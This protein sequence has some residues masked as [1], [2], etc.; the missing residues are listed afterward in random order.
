[1]S[2][3]TE[4]EEKMSDLTKKEA[5]QLVDLYL[6]YEFSDQFLLISRETTNYASLFHLVDTGILTMEEAFEAL[7]H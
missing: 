5:Q 4:A 1:M 7:L 2:E 3:L 6:T